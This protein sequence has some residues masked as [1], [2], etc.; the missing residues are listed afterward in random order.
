MRKESKG[1]LGIDRRRWEFCLILLCTI[2]VG[3]LAVGVPKS[4][5]VEED[6]LPITLYSCTDGVASPIA[7][8]LDGNDVSL[9]SA[10]EVFDD[11]PQ[12]LS[13]G[14]GNTSSVAD[15][16]Y[17]IVSAIDSTKVLDI[18]GGSRDTGA[19]LQIYDSNG[20]DAQHFQITSGD[21]GCTITNIASGMVLDVASAGQE[22]GTNVWQYDSNGTDAQKWSFVAADSEAWYIVSLCNGLYLDIAGANTANGTNVW[23]YTGN[24]TLAQQFFLSS[25]IAPTVPIAPTG[26]T[27]ED[28]TYYIA[29]SG[30]QAKV[31]DIAAGSQL[32]CA[33]LQIY[34]KNSTDAQRFEITYGDDGYY[35]ISN[36]NSGKVLDVAGAGKESGTNVWQYS[37]NDT[38][39]QKWNIVSL[40]GSDYCFQSICNGLYLTTQGGNLQSGTNV[41][42]WLPDGRGN[43]TSMQRFVLIEDNRDDILQ[44]GSEG[45]CFIIESK[46]DPDKVI[47]VTGASGLAG[48]NVQLYSNNGTNAQKFK[49]AYCDDGLYTIESINARR[50]IS[51]AGI[52]S[53][54]GYNV[55]QSGTVADPGMYWLAVLNDD[56]TYSFISHRLRMCLDVAGGNTAVGTNICAFTCNGTDAQRFILVATKEAPA[57]ADGLYTIASGLALNKAIDVAASL[58]ECSN[59]RLYDYNY[60]RAQKWQLDW[61]ET[62]AGSYY[63]ITNL[64]SGLLLS[65]QDA[66]TTLCANV[67][68]QASA[69]L[70]DTT[71]ALA[72]R[73]S[74]VRTGSGSLGIASLL[75]GFYVDVTGAQTANGTNIQMYVRNDTAAQSFAFESNRAVATGTYKLKAAQMDTLL[76]GITGEGRSSLDNLE[77]QEASDGSE[78]QSFKITPLGNGYYKLSAWC[79]NYVLDVAEAVVASGTNVGQHSENGSLA[80]QWLV[81]LDEDGYYRIVSALT[82]GD[83]IEYC[84]DILDGEVRAGANLGIE[85]IARE[86]LSQLFQLEKIQ[87]LP[88][89]HVAANNNLNNALADILDNYCNDL[90]SCFNYVAYSY[91]YAERG[92]WPSYENWQEDYA[93]HMYY[94][95]A[96]NCYSFASLFCYLSRALNYE[97]NV[98]CGYCL[99]GDPDDPDW[100]SHGWTEVIKNGAAYVCDP[101]GYYEVR[102]GN[103]FMTTYDTSS[104]YYVKV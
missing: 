99:A 36:R 47:D 88:F 103:F 30:N 57:L 92:I 93:L 39:A 12:G 23:V 18:A 86:A 51:V 96:G 78:N 52:A 43:L 100:S 37:S 27:I 66:A 75:S 64:A 74:L 63:T 56:G 15:G 53:G 22:A 32:D 95:G 59:A 79:S 49:I 41:Y 8:S 73:W 25:F 102:G 94:D 82:A 28:G 61:H 91:S 33:N 3:F 9:G 29:A 4:H 97:T 5:A 81:K 58:L 55:E 50:F 69:Q 34:E 60:T 26:K 6:E 68:Q 40:G 71:E 19:N 13:V 48:A 45:K 35:S 83:E 7:D 24:R 21:N 10:Q 98:I 17:T 11:A 65:I 85:R 89:V 67:C 104:L 80:Q 101:E 38:F 72:Q 70:S 62:D 42:V 76:L 54:G 46:L 20:T 87:S 77:L 16:V 31:F 84:L 90:Y 44:A 14:P 2:L 1:M